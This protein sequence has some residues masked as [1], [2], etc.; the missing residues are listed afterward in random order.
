MSLA[1]KP[2]AMLFDLSPYLPFE[3]FVVLAL[4]AIAAIAAGQR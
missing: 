1:W 4:A 2:N 3:A